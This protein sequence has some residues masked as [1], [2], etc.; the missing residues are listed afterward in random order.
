M[1][2]KVREHFWKSARPVGLDAE[3][4]TDIESQMVPSRAMPAHAS[5]M[6]RSPATLARLG[7]R[8]KEPA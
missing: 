3:M 4:L 6:V 7:W 8:D 2:G 5:K 1:H